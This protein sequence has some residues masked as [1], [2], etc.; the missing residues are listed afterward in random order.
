MPGSIPLL[1]PFLAKAVPIGQFQQIIDMKY[2][3]RFSRACRGVPVPHFLRKIGTCLGQRGIA[4]RSFPS[5]N[6]AGG[7]FSRELFQVDK[8]SKL[9]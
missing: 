8:E 3:Y 1:R 2:E 9:K 4:E 5:F 6:P 7:R